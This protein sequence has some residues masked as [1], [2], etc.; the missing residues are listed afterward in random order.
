MD[1]LVHDNGKTAAVRRHIT[2]LVL[3]A[4]AVGALAFNFRLICAG[5]N[6]EYLILAK[7]IA[8]GRGYR[9]LAEPGAPTETKR[10]PGYPLF[11]A[12]WMWLFGERLWVLKATSLVCF[13]GAAGLG[14]LL[15]AR[16]PGAAPWIAAGGI[17]MFVLNEN[18]LHYASVVGTEMPFTL[19]G[20][21][22]LLTL[23]LTAAEETRRW[24]WGIL[25]AALIAAAIYVRPNGLSLIP[26]ALVFL[27]LRRRWATAILVTVL[28]GAAILP[29]AWYQARA[30]AGG[31]H[32]Y[33]AATLGQTEE[34]AETQSEMSK[35]LYRIR[36]NA[37]AH[38]LSL[39]QS[40]L[41]RPAHLSFVP[42]VPA[43]PAVTSSHPDRPSEAT[44]KAPGADTS[45][46]IDWGHLSRYMLTVLV[47]IGA[48][49]TWRG[50]GSSMHWYVI[51]TIA[52]LL[53]TPWP[54]GRYLFPL[55][56]FFGWFLVSSIV[57]LARLMD[58]W[59]GE[60]RA[61]KLGYLGVASACGL[62][63]L[64]TSM[65]ISQQLI[66]NLRCRGLPYS[67][68]ERYVYE[69]L[70]VANYMRAAAWI[71]DNTPPDAVIAC[72]KPY[73]VYWVTRRRA[74]M[75][76]AESPEDVWK[77]LERLSESGPVYVIKD[78]FGDRYSERALTHRYWR[79]ALAQH[80][81]GVRMVFESQAPRTSVWRV[82]HEKA[83]TRGHNACSAA[84]RLAGWARDSHASPVCDYVR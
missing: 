82:R 54:R 9:M 1:Q 38:A 25:A 65:A 57:W 49:V 36:R 61:G 2:A 70:D 6:A 8:E 32:T 53:V 33:L 4:L 66:A 22:A 12:G 80:H 56:P 3:A 55:L 47:I 44:P 24:R 29:W 84:T 34:D 59:I 58:G 31:E 35:Y 18:S 41:A 45:G 11:L 27:M 67:A 62:A 5:D 16:Q 76:W 21:G 50:G 74:K 48:V 40:L 60:H 37:A 23:E 51:F 64:L 42:V 14:Y 81:E 63:L 77:G 13:A 15:V 10:P 52:M 19:L 71:K 69:G 43:L 28:A 78:A 30:T 75:V 72:R 7:S 39:G 68:P 79:N 83:Q 46:G 17:L 20:I 73:N 26:A